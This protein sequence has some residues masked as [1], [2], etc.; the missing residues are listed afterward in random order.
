MPYFSKGKV[1]WN[2]HRQADLFSI[3]KATNIKGTKFDDPANPVAPKGK[4][5]SSVTPATYVSFVNYVDD[6]Q[7]ARFGLH[8]GAFESSVQIQRL[9][10]LL[11]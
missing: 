1:K 5:D 10:F 9:M 11:R 8:N 7:L 2:S 3:S 4:L 6:T